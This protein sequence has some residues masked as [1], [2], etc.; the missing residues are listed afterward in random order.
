MSDSMMKLHD[1]PAGLITKAKRRQ[2]RLATA[3]GAPV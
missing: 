1:R 2:W 3:G